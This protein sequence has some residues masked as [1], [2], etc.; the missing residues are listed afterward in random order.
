MVGVSSRS[1]TTLTRTGCCTLVP[2][3]RLC[4][5]TGCE[6]FLFGGNEGEAAY[7]HKE[8]TA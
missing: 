3:K 8:S 2:S 6:P 5:L 4:T 1:G 7:F